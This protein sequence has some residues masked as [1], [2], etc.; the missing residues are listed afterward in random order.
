MALKLCS[1]ASP[2]LTSLD[3]KKDVIESVTRVRLNS[4][5]AILARSP[6]N[7]PLQWAP[8]ITS[9]IIKA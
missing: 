2:W 5:S 9:S 6:N 8:V 4:L 1:R 7:S 3:C